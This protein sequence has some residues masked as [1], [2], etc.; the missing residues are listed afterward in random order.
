MGDCPAVHA[1]EHDAF[2]WQ[3]VAWLLERDPVA[4]T[5]A[6]AMWHRGDLGPLLCY[7][8]RPHD[9]AVRRE[10]PCR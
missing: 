1:A 6:E 4:L 7:A 8:V 10:Q 2:T 3:D 9:S 5:A